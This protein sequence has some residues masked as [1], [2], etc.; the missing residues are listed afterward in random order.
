MGQKVWVIS[1]Q[2][3]QRPPKR[4]LPAKPLPEEP[5]EQEEAP[6]EVS[7][8]APRK[9]PALS[10]SISL[11]VWGGGQLFLGK[12]R[13]GWGLV[14]GMALFFLLVTAVVV[15]PLPAGRLAGRLGLRP[16]AVILVFAA[17][18]LVGLFVWVGNAV[19]AYFGALRTWS[20]PYFGMGKALW[21][22]GASVLFPGWGQFLNGQPIKG[23]FFLLF[24]MAGG[25]S[26]FVFAVTRALWPALQADPARRMFEVY[27]GAAVLF[28]PVFIL[29]WIVAAYDAFR[30]N[31]K[32]Q[33]KKLC[34]KN[35]GYRPGGPKVLRALV[36]RGSAILGLLL[37][38]SLGMQFFPKTY[39]R[40]SLETIRAEMLKSHVE[41]V[42]EL[43]QKVIDVIGRDG[44][45]QAVQ[46]VPGPHVPKKGGNSPAASSIGGDR[47]GKPL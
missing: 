37:A 45:P 36:P 5:Q 10:F 28:L 13:P 35:P 17:F 1:D 26:L 14:A 15:F 38:M 39:Y 23:L 44:S 4:N 12:K 7:P 43:V 24:G 34:R 47:S 19:A 11:V 20:E 18:F 3:W 33:R 41:I 27:L 9:N 2:E 29:A 42:P 40:D 6:A 46:P 8:E 21:P 30:S 22:V 31:Q 16:G 32:Q 25:F